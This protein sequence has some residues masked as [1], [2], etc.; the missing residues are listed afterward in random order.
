[1]TKSPHRAAW[2]LIAA[3]SWTSRTANAL[4]IPPIYADSLAL[5]ERA[6]A[7]SSCFSGF[8]V[9]TGFVGLPGDFCCPTGSVCNVLAGNTT[10]LC[11]PD[12]ESCSTINPITCDLS[13]QD[14]SIHPQA[15]I[16]T[17]A[18]NG[19]LTKCGSLCCPFG[20]NCNGNGLC[21]LEDNQ[22]AAPLQNV[23]TTTAST[24]MTT[25]TASTTTSTSAAA[26]TTSPAATATTAAHTTAVQSSAGGAV[27]VAVPTTQT[28]SAGTSPTSSRTGTDSN[29]SAVASADDSANGGKQTASIVGGVVGGL[30]GL[31]LVGAGIWFLCGRRLRRGGSGKA[32]SMSGGVGVGGR[33][34]G[35]GMRQRE[36]MNFM[37]DTNKLTRST[38]SFGNIINNPLSISSPKP[39]GDATAFRTDFI[40][41]LPSSRENSRPS[42]PASSTVGTVGISGRYPTSVASPLSL[43]QSM[44][45]RN[46]PSPPSPSP[47]PLVLT[48]PP[49]REHE[50]DSISVT[51]IRGMRSSPPRPQ[52]QPREPSMEEINVGADPSIIGLGVG[53]FTISPPGTLLPPTRTAAATVTATAM[54][55]AVT[56]ASIAGSASSLGVPRDRANDRM[57]TFSSLLQAA[58]LDPER[59]FVPNSAQSSP[60]SRRR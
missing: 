46:L 18:L 59:P 10:L 48:R 52:H 31:L 37:S 8:N 26:E 20:Y 49:L 17:T 41:K 24:A 2:L 25:S 16:K 60:A 9:C 19:V 7:S 39:Q 51:P 55:A 23:P 15:P 4:F 36:P 42:T 35:S 28:T 29:E 43:G 47:P 54:L 6:T 45:N 13:Q 40:R 22:N 58:N 12:G 11:C 53:N 30:A 3:A 56:Q 34:G 50:R 44:M 21:I 38:S 32:S 5:F 57:T 33:L 1:M 14:A 27:T